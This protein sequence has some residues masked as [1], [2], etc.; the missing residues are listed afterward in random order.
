MRRLDRFAHLLDNAYRIPL[1]RRRI[2][3][4]GIVGLVPGVGDGITAVIA[5]I[6]PAQAWRRGA[7]PSFSPAQRLANIG[8]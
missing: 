3:L 4:D 2:G 7:S 1:T 8:A 5:L 6:P